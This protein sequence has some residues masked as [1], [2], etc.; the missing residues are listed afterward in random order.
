MDSKIREQARAI[1]RTAKT[2]QTATLAKNAGVNV[3]LDCVAKELTLPQ[4]S[5][6][7]LIRDH[8]AISIKELASA[9]RVSSPSAS[10]MVDRLVDIGVLSREP[11]RVDRRE[12][13][14][15]LSEAGEEVVGAMEGQL[16]E[17]I[18]EL[19]EKVGP[20]V[21]GKWCEVYKQLDAVLAE[22]KIQRS[23]DLDNS[24][25]GSSVA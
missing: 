17:G 6:L 15:T 2:L 22:E 5:T 21:A 1:Y 8:G 3:G 25:R 9:T 11:S 13:C 24:G 12:V 7:V 23:K 10:A 20:E 19:L 4:M 16:L 18:E 14:I